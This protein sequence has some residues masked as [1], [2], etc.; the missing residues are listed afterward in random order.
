MKHPIVI[1][2]LAKLK[3]QQKPNY[4][5]IL[6]K[7]LEDHQIKGE[8]PKL[9][10]HSC[11]AVCNTVALDLL[12]KYM[13]ITVYFYNPNIHPKIEFKRRAI[14]QQKFINEYNNVRDTQIKYIEGNYIPEEFFKL[15]KGMENHKEARGE[16]CN[17]CYRL[18]M[19]HGAKKAIELNAD[20]FMSSLTFSPMKDA[21]KINNIGFELAEEY[22]IMFLPSDLK[23]NNGSMISRNLVKEYDVFRQEYCGCIFASK[24]QGIN[25]RDIVKSAR[26]YINNETKD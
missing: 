5:N 11:C 10:I 20:Y 12:N 15:T 21:L 2:E 6:M 8:R 23:K 4:Q 14:A 17:V 9:L 7:I 26:K 13:D 22:N 1:E 19:S 16:R 25:M 18:R 24:D 3:D